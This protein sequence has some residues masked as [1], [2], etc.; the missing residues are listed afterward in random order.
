MTGPAAGPRHSLTSG[1]SPEVPK[2]EKKRRIIAKSIFGQ[3]EGTT[4][5]LLLI[6]YLGTLGTSA[7]GRSRRNCSETT[8]FTSLLHY[9]KVEV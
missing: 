6:T 9:I 4:D 1:G 8:E 2:G 3:A 7:V 5:G